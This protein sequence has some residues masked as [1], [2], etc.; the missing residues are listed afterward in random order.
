MKTGNSAVVGGDSK[1]NVAMKP[2]K[3]EA[4][5]RTERS[6]CLCCADERH[7]YVVFYDR[8]IIDLLFLLLLLSIEGKQHL[9]PNTPSYYN[10][11]YAR[12]QDVCSVV[13]NYTA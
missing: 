1:Q 11:Q 9:G 3:Y 8:S 13:Q 4:S 10:K 12:G 2:A 7:C 5:T 6:L